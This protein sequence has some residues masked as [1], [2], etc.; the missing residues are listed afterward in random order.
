MHMLVEEI[1]T[2]VDAVLM[3]FI[4]SFVFIRSFVMKV[5][6]FINGVTLTTAVNNQSH[7][8]STVERTD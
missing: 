5:S 1:A 3:V 2:M 4:I 8:G 7:A 6:K